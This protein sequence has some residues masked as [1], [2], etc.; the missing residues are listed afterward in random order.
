MDSLYWNRLIPNLEIVPTT[1]LFFK[2]YPYRLELLAYAGQTISKPVAIE[3]SLAYRK[4]SVRQINYGG[5]WAA[6][7]KQNIKNADVEWLKYLQKF[8]Q[9]PSFDCKIRIEEP[10]VQIYAE[11]E[12]DL[13]NF[14]QA[15]PAEYQ[16]YVR[17]VSRPESDAARSLVLSGKK[18][19]KNPPAYRFKLAFRDGKYDYHVR[20]SVLQYLDSLGDLVR[21]PSH[22]RDA[23]TRPY[24][25][26]W[27]CYVY[28]NDVK[29]ATFIQLMDPNL[30]RS[31]IEMAAVSE[32]NTDIIQESHNG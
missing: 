22:F 23:F 21:V 15:L 19:Q 4:I 27:D 31:I 26:I 10:N 29:I 20:Q 3:E 28:S 2:Q 24:N 16:K 1:K 5:S 6:K 13:Y 30:I 14:V 9:D 11:R 25:S 7:T 18:L 8:K 32:I 17:R 12:E